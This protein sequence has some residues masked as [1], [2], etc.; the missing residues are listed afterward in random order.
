MYEVF[1]KVNIAQPFQSLLSK[2]QNVETL[3]VYNLLFFYS[4]AWPP[5]SGGNLYSSSPITRMK[6]QFLRLSI[7]NSCL[8][9]GA[10][11]TSPLLCFE[12]Q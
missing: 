1:E 6:G 12:A 2:K 7:R 9:Y 3:F 10:V 11:L 5:Y 4:G 8:T